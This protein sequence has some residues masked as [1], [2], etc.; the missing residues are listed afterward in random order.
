MNTILLASK[1]KDKCSEIERIIRR[2]T[3]VRYNILT[4]ND[5]PEYKDVEETG[6]SFEENALIKLHA[7]R[8]Y[9]LFDNYIIISEDSGL[10]I[11]ELA[12]APGIYSGRY[13]P[14]WNECNQRVLREMF[15]AENRDAYL[16][17]AIAISKPGWS[18][19]D[20]RVFTGI[21]R[22]VISDREKGSNGFSY[23]KIFMLSY[24]DEWKTL[25][26]IPD[27]FLP[28]YFRYIAIQQAIDIL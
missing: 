26:E 22:G 5:F 16:H 13:A 21:M 18:S 2:C 15:G 9:H 17:S 10:C 19:Y 1:N 27:K 25:A 12:G 14:N 24:Y 11:S 28:Y 20:S 6:H 3:C 23:D 8:Q 7:A 4:L